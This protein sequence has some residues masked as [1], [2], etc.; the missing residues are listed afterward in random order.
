MKGWVGFLADLQR[1][2]YLYKWLPISCRSSA[3]QWKFA[4]QRPTFYHWA[5]QP[6]V[7]CPCHVSTWQCHFNQYI[8]NNNKNNDNVRFVAWKLLNLLTY[9]LTYLLKSDSSLLQVSRRSSSRRS[10]TRRTTSASAAHWGYT[11]SATRCRWCRGT[12]TRSCCPRA[13]AFV[14]SAATTD[15]TRWPCYRRN[16]TTSASTSASLATNT[17]RSRVA[18]GCFA[19]VSCTGCG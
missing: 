1:T 4:D 12:G 3:D 15:V 10:A 18:R 6:T 14:S 19:E 16:P 2:V 8:D 13:A 11:S 5:N 9:L 17:E 7:Q